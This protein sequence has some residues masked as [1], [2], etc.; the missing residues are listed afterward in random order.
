MLSSTSVNMEKPLREACAPDGIV[1]KLVSCN[2][3]DVL[4]AGGCVS[5]MCALRSMRL[6]LHQLF[7]PSIVADVAHHMTTMVKRR[8]A[9]ALQRF[10][11][12]NASLQAV[13]VVLEGSDA[14]RGCPQI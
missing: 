11:C 14:V 10:E 4:G 6:L 7:L 9:E 5:L 12:W 2:L 13:R 3:F 8:W 1:H